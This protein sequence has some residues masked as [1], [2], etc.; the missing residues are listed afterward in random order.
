MRL[1]SAIRAGIAVLAL[2]ALVSVTTLIF[3]E[4][5]LTRTAHDLE[6]NLHS[7]RVAQGLQ[8]AVLE[9][10][11]T[12]NR[13]LLTADPL[14]RSEADKYQAQ[15]QQLL[16]ES[17]NYVGDEEEAAL[18]Q[19]IQAEIDA[20][21][22]WR[23]QRAPEPGEL[24]PDT[25]EWADRAVHQ[26]DSLLQE[27]VALD[28]AESD[29]AQLRVAQVRGLVEKVAIGPLVANLLLG[30]AVA[31][32]AKRVLFGPLRHTRKLAAALIEGETGTPLQRPAFVEIREIEEALTSAA[33]QLAE[34]Q[35]RQLGFLAGVAHDLRNPLSALRL[36]VASLGRDRPLPDETRL[37]SML[38]L[39]E[40]Q[41]TR[42][43]RLVGDLL[44]ATR[45]EAGELELRKERRAVTELVREVIELFRESSQR[46]ISFRGTDCLADVDA[47][48]IEQVVTNLVSNALKYS[49]EASPIEVE[50]TCEQGEVMVRVRDYGIGI[51]PEDLPHIFEPFRRARGSRDNVP[52][53]GLGLSVSRKIAEAHGGRIDVESRL[54]EGSTFTL[55]LPAASTDAPD[56]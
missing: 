39:V 35:Q 22:S 49:P 42:L 9:H 18:L 47:V 54:G 1:S 38:R 28:L 13:Y 20:Y 23:R 11:R 26:L 45:I 10:A 46:P 53:V 16:K 25:L 43:D 24:D 2:L 33:R 51:A 36:A 15:V 29:A 44:D 19:Q 4:R 21:L 55:R 50:V 7:V 40:R 52:G 3:A 27:M 12:A 8:L 37:R 5:Y 6:D 34:K 17:W 56:A 14:F 32:L 30:I 48:R 31:V 41:I